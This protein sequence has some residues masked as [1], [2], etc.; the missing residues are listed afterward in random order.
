MLESKEVQESKMS[1]GE[2]PYIIMCNGKKHYF[3]ESFTPNIEVIAYALSH[4]NR[5]TGHAGICS[6]AQHSMLV[7]QQLPDELKLSGL[8]HDATEAY[9][10]DIAKPLKNLLPDYQKIEAFHADII[11]KHFNVDTR[12]PLIKEVDTRMLVTEAKSFGLQ[13]IS[14]SLSNV[15]P[16]DFEIQRAMPFK[17]YRA[18]Y[19][20]F[21]ELGGE[22]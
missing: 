12:H 7:V 16:Y 9:L 14:E 3:D 1:I 10:G 5:F 19:K 13:Y 8:L 2:K 21:I 22:V 6:V 4:I 11:D 15:V 20:M 17:A 18:F